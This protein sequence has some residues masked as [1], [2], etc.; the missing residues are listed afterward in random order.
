MR[1]GR[2]VILD[3]GYLA[4]HLFN[5]DGEYER[6][7]RLPG[8]SGRMMHTDY[9]PYPGGEAVISA[10]GSQPLVIQLFDGADDQS[11]TTRP[12]ER[13]ML[14]GEVVTRDT[15]AEGWLPPGGAPVTSGE[16]SGKVFGPRMLPG[17]LPN[18]SVA[19]SDPSA[20][21]TRCPARGKGASPAGEP[22]G[23]SASGQIRLAIGD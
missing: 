22:S 9:L 11:H 5:A 23:T 21:A 12:V 10:V 7:V 14:P 3:T 16:R 13:L 1:D 17:V 18:G 8:G 15:V 20:Y 6:R 2:V 19:F 4:Y